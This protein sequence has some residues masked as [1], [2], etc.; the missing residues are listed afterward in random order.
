MHRR[1]VQ[2]N[3]PS[4]NN[5]ASESTRNT[6]QLETQ[7]IGIADY[8]NGPELCVAMRAAAGTAT[9]PKSIIASS[10]SRR[11]SLC[12]SDMITSFRIAP[13]SGAEASVLELSCRKYA[14]DP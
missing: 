3:A 9:A 1:R 6:E 7:A 8:P 12:C 11:L 10:A 13:R 2:R 14:L 4:W 5:G